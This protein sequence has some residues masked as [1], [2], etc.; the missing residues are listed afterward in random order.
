MTNSLEGI[1]NLTN[2]N[3]GIVFGN[4]QRLKTIHIGEMVGSVIQR[5]GRRVPILMKNVRYVPELYCDLFSIS[6]VLKGGCYL[7]G[8]LKMKKISKAG[9]VYVIDRYI[10]SGTCFLFAMKIMSKDKQG[11]KKTERRSDLMK[12][13]QEMGHSSEDL[14]RA[15][16][17]KMKGS[18]QHCE[19]CGVGMTK[20][21]KKNKEFMP[22]TKKVGERI[23]R[24]ISSIKHGS[25]GGAKFWALFMDDSSDFLINRFLKKKS[26]LA[27]MGTTLLKRL[28]AENKIIMNTI[29][30]DNAGE[31]K[32]MEEMSIN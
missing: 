4:G 12:I 5:Y 31:N 23:F 32:K 2:V 13:H 28:K 9:K 11:L 30:C 17:L 29:R 18:M 22:R 10:K 6:A 24:D 19:G 8:N 16:G 21:K 27:K 25:A 7:E 1:K 3:S 20:Q 26:N 15:T 14:T